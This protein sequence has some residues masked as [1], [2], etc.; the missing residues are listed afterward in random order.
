M[1][2]Q[3]EVVVTVKHL[4]ALDGSVKKTRSQRMRFVYAREEGEYI[5]LKKPIPVYRVNGVA[6]VSVF[7]KTVKSEM[8]ATFLVKG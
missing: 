8:G 4:A 6:H 2:K 3:K 7:V 5:D 1:K